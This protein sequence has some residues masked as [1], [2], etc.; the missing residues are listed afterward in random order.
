VSE[1]SVVVCA[2]DSA[3]WE[4]LRAAL[5]SLEE[6]VLQ[7]REVI[8][9]VDHNPDLLGRARTELSGVRVIE[10]TDIAGLGGA[11]NSGIAASSGS[12]VAFLDDDA[13]AS[14]EWLRALMERY[15]DVDVAAVGGS[16]EPMWEGERPA[17]FPPEF[18]W[19]LGCSFLGMPEKAQDV[20]NLFGCNMSFRRELLDE[21]GGFRLG[22]GCD[23]TELCIRLTQRWPKKK[24]LYMPE[25]KVFHHVP[26]SR[27]RIRRFVSRCYFEGG[28]KAVVTRLVGA[29]IG[30]A[31]EY[32]YTVSVLPAGVRRG[33]ADF[34]RRGDP[35]G[36]ARAAAIV[37]GLTATTA[38]YV[39]GS[40]FT[41]RAAK[42][43]GW[44]GKLA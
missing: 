12:V 23:E 36:L 29:G 17:W 27:T 3:R 10:N 34:F 11:R 38:G 14:P 19:V 28:S 32:R 40:L 22:Y 37:T 8:V 30:L 1:I 9:V 31:S 44:S 6:Q 39:V 25:A 21:L 42:E 20:R 7:P 16:A 35:Y 4:A 2:H 18:D 15:G 26:A 43:R 33:L 5:R 13:V 41:T 24:L